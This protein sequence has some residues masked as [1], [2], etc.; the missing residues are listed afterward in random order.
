MV[1]LH[2]IEGH[3]WCY[4]STV[5]TIKDEV[6]QQDHDVQASRFRV[7]FQVRFMGAGS[8]YSNT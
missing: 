3:Y 5:Q 1:L 6:E 4:S 7:L 8:S 2:C